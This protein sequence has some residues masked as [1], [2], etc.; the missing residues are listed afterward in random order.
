MRND[1][2]T[3]QRCKFY[4]KCSALYCRESTMLV[5]QRSATIWQ[6]AL[7]STGY[8]VRLYLPQTP[9]APVREMEG[10]LYYFTVPFGAHPSEFKGSS[11][12]LFAVLDP[13]QLASMIALGRW[14]RVL[15]EFRPRVAHVARAG[16]TGIISVLNIPDPSL[17]A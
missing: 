16:P 11:F 17:L 15:L 13:C 7:Y 10:Q 4:S 12:D 1:V 14:L 9:L 5:V 3:W 2:P 6:W 8:R